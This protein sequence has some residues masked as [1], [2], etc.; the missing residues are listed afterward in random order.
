MKRVPQI[1]GFREEPVGTLDKHLNVL[2]LN[3]EL[4]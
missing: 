3:P 2:E 4:P 1:L